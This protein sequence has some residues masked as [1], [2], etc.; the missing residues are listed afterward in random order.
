MPTANPLHHD[1]IKPDESLAFSFRPYY[2]CQPQSISEMASC[3]LPGQVL[4]AGV[5]WPQQSYSYLFPNLCPDST[6]DK[7]IPF[8]SQKVRRVIDWS[9]QSDRSHDHDVDG[10][11]T[12]GYPIVLLTSDALYSVPV[13]CSVHAWHYVRIAI[14]LLLHSSPYPG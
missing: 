7:P 2:S 13:G 12:S 10:N 3:Q 8:N 5:Y 9:C 11:R 1:L 6:L 14:W 4:Q